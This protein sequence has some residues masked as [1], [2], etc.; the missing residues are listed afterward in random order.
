MTT[1]KSYS[2]PPHRHT[3]T[4]EPD[5]TWLIEFPTSEDEGVREKYLALGPLDDDLMAREIALLF[6]GTN[7]TADD[8]DPILFLG[9]KIAVIEDVLWSMPYEMRWEI[10]EQVRRMVPNWGPKE[11]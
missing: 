5:W 8:G 2:Q 4:K 7:I 6:G 1:F 9:D 10:W 11:A 3:F